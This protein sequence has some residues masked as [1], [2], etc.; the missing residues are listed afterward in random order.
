MKFVLIRS[1]SGFG[2]RVEHLSCVFHY[3]LKVG[4][5]MVIDWTDHVWCGEEIEKEFSYYFILNKVNFMKLNEFKLLFIKNKKSGNEMTFLPPFY[6]DV[7]LRRSDETEVKYRY[8]D[9]QATIKEICLGK[10]KDF[11]Q[12]VLVTTDLD[13]RN[14][15]GIVAIT[16]L[17]YRPFIMDYIKQD[18]NYLFLMNNK[19]IT[20]HLR[21]SDRS[22]YT[23]THRPDLTNYSHHKE[24]Y[25][26]NLIKKI[27]RDTKNILLISD[28]TSLVE[29]FLEIID[30]KYNIIQTNN[31]KT[32]E[33]VGLHLEKTPSKENKNLELLKDF[34]FMTNST[35]VICDE[36]SR[37]SLTAMRICKLKKL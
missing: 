26:Q 10:R 37:F 19:F 25:V 35:D 14:S 16:N 36:V 8:G 29:Y 18:P 7:V 4:R 31:Q 17:V 11:E 9:L 1:F 12:D 28:S 6:S 13:K 21:G 27:P 3:C 2:D 15:N 33:N 32:S 30:K 5:T 22:K 20:V 34:Y 23:E 24:T